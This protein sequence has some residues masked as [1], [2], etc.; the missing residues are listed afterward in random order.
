[1]LRFLIHAPCEVQKPVG[2]YDI[3]VSF[4]TSLRIDGAANI[5]ELAQKVEGIDG[6]E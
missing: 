4:G 5:G 3:V 2:W 1:M 6:Q